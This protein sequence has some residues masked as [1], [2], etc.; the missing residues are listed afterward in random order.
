[1]LKISYDGLEENEKNI[2]LDIACLFKGENVEYITKI[3]DSFDF[4]PN[5]GLKVLMD[6][7]LIIIDQNKRLIMHDLLQDMGRKIVHQESPNEPGKRN[8]LWFH[9]DVHDVLEENTV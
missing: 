4:F 2:F 8:R 5:I 1:M 9:E 6:K 3:L 7:S